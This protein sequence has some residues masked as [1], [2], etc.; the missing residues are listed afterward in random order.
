MKSHGLVL[1]KNEQMTNNEEVTVIFIF[2]T[3]MVGRL[4]KHTLNV[5]QDK[6]HH[7]VEQF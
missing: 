7:M 2:P 6:Y 4:F 5:S 1:S 3:I